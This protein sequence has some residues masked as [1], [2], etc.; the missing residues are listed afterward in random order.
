MKRK[1]II[2]L[3]CLFGTFF[4]TSCTTVN[5]EINETIK[6]PQ[7]EKVYKN[8]ICEREEYID[9]QYYLYSTGAKY[10]AKIEFD[11]EKSSIHSYTLNLEI[12]AKNAATN[13][14]LSDYAKEFDSFCNEDNDGRF[15]KCSY[16]NYFDETKKTVITGDYELFKISNLPTDINSAKSFLETRHKMSCT[17][18]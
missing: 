13:D 16:K 14:T 8:I 1:K 9:T 5:N 7:S 3:L 6:N 12:Y 10:I 18:K 2:L 17:I 15:K 11:E 4:L